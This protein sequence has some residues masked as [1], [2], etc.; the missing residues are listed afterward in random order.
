MNCRD[1]SS[2]LD[3]WLDAHSPAGV[4]SSKELEAPE[5]QAHIALCPMCREQYTAAQRLM[6]GL[7]LLPRVAAPEGFS[8]R[9]VHR[10][11]VD[12]EERRLSLQRRLRFTF[13]LAASILI[14]VIAGYLW[15][16]GPRKG[17]D[18]PVVK[19]EPPKIEPAKDDAKPKDEKPETAPALAQR[20]DEATGRVAA[21]TGKLTD[22]TL[23]HAKH[24]LAAAPSFE[25]PTGAGPAEPID[26]AASLRQAGAELTEGLQPV[27]RSARRAMDSFLREISTFEVGGAH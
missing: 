25:F 20:V 8:E 7:K 5:P 15:L 10:A 13:A 26:P 24:L 1:F 16:P 19:Q 23:A 12:R 11:L 3:T 17:N 18:G 27:T 21:F 22:K 6:E 4:E 9:M 2:W 14:M